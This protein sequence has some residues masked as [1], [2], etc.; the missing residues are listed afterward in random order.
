MTDV[1]RRIKS[2]NVDILNCILDCIEHRFV[3]KYFSL[4]FQWYKIRP[5]PTL[6]SIS[7]PY[8]RAWDSLEPPRTI[9]LGSRPGHHDYASGS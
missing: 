8:L 9:F 6:E 2:L 7:L 5:I 4:A 3:G 1:G